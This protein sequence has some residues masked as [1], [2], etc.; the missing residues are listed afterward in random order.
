[1]FGTLWRRGHVSAGTVVCWKKNSHHILLAH[2]CSLTHAH[3]VVAVEDVTLQIASNADAIE[4]RDLGSGLSTLMFCLD[5]SSLQYFIRAESCV[6]GDEVFLQ[7]ITVE[8]SYHIAS[9]RTHEMT[10]A[11]GSVVAITFKDIPAARDFVIAIG[12]ALPPGEF[13]GVLCVYTF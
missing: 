1:M 12:T 6:S 10:F 8:S 9:V 11:D 5:Y 2:Y 3:T 4:W 7:F 13:Y